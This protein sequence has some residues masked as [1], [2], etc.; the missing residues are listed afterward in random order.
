MPFGMPMSGQSGQSGRSPFLIQCG[1]HMATL[2]FVFYPTPEHGL[3]KSVGMGQSYSPLYIQFMALDHIRNIKSLLPMPSQKDHP[4]HYFIALIYE[5]DILIRIT[6]NLISQLIFLL[7][8]VIPSIG[9][10]KLQHGTSNLQGRSD[11]TAGNIDTLYL[12]VQ[13]LHVHTARLYR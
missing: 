5:I 8:H 1:Q 9:G 13:Y 12:L 6:S 10:S 7:L 11:G 3:S 2:K 4:F